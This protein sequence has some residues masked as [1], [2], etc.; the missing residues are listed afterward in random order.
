MSTTYNRIAGNNLDRLSALSDGIFAVAMTLLVLVVRVPAETIAQVHSE[1]ELWHALGALAP[2]LVAYLLSFTMLGTF[3]LGQQTQLNHLDGVDRNLA[4]IHIGFLA[5]VT[6]LP[7]ST[8]LLAEFAELRTAVGVYWLN[9]LLLGLM[10]AAS[11]GYAGRAGRFK[12]ETTGPER[13][14]LRRRI[15]VAQVLYGGAALLCL[16]DPYVSIGALILAQAYFVF[17]PNTPLRRR[18]PDQT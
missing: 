18:R 1:G 11:I 12:P 14:A 2:Q 10:L 17:S 8:S 6:L 15:V 3:W 9:L 4:W 7:F 16:V 13:R 5:G